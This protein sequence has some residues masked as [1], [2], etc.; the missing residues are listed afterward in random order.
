[1]CWRQRYTQGPIRGQVLWETRHSV[2]RAPALPAPLPAPAYGPDGTRLALAVH[3]GE[4]CELDGRWRKSSVRTGAGSR[5]DAALGEAE[6]RAAP[7]GDPALTT[8][9]AT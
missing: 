5:P 7:E 9:G 1:M 6:S 4:L 2:G 3:T 8:A